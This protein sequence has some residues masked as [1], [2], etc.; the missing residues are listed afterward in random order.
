LAELGLID[1]VIS[2]PLGGAHR[3]FVMTTES[4][5]SELVRRVEGLAALPVDELVTKRYERYRNV[6]RFQTISDDA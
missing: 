4:V 5:R 3:D 1:A 2:E 6:G